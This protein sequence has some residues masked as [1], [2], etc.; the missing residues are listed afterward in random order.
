MTPLVQMEEAERQFEREQ[1]AENRERQQIEDHRR[2]PESA[3]P[4]VEIET[5]GEPIG[6]DT[7][8]YVPHRPKLIHKSRSRAHDS[9][10][11]HLTSEGIREVTTNRDRVLPPTS[12]MP[13]SVTQEMPHTTWTSVSDHE[14]IL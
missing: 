6:I 11:D 9:S 1:T 13:N 2:D 14:R 3:A 5:T 7:T 8:P 12:D 10:S 4:E